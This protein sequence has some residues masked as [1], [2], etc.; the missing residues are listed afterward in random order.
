MNVSNKIINNYKIKKMKNEKKKKGTIIFS[1][2]KEVP[3][4]KHFCTPKSS[5]NSETEFLLA[6]PPEIILQSKQKK[7]N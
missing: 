3:I 5:S 4:L 6:E 2:E 7:N 1:E